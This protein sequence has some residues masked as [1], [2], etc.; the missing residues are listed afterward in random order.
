MSLTWHD[1]EVSVGIGQNGA[2]VLRCSIVLL[3]TSI[4]LVGTQLL[5][6]LMFGGALSC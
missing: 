5:E 2:D 4:S 1:S 6:E 3:I